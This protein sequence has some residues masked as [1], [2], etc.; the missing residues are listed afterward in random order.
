M[1]ADGHPCGRPSVET[2]CSTYPSAGSV[3]HWAGSLAP[4]KYAPI[5]SY[6]T[7]WINFMAF[8]AILLSA[9]GNDFIDAARDPDSD[10]DVAGEDHAEAYFVGAPM[11][12]QRA[13]TSEQWGLVREILTMRTGTGG[14]QMMAA[15]AAIMEEFPDVA[16]APGSCRDQVPPGPSQRRR[17]GEDLAGRG[18]W[19]QQQ[20]T[21]GTTKRSECFAGRWQE[22]WGIW[23][24]PLAQRRRWRIVADE[25]RLGLA[26]VSQVMYLDYRR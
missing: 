12:A 6:Y 18:R 23:C 19:W 5:Y 20:N 21:T 9:A 4:P 26:T 7:G 24:V 14:A 3:Y 17:S 8:D 16:Q 15:S 1:G 13:L 22:L 11:V 2:I 10:G 25:P